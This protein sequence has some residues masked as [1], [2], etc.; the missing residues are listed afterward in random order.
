MTIRRSASA[1]IAR[2]IEEFVSGDTHRRELASARLA[3]IGSRATTALLGLATDAARPTIVRTSALETLQAIGDSRA[4]ALAHTLAAEP[5]DDALAVAAIDLLGQIARGADTRAT[6]AFDRLASIVVA[7]EASTTRRLA[8]LTA[9][10]GQPENLLKPLY[11]SLAKDPASK[12]VARAT[13]RQAG[14]VESL[15]T[16]VSRGLPGDPDIIGAVVR[17]DGDTTPLTTLKKAIDAIRL[18]ERAA[19]GD[20]RA[21]WAV[22]RGAV[23]QLLAARNSRLGLYDLRETLEQAKGPLPVGFLSAAAVVGDA[24]CLTPIAA[25]WM[26]TSPDDRWWREH[27]ADAF[28]SIVTREGL[29]R[30]NPVLTKI[31]AKWPGAGVL[32]A[33]ARQNR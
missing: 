1:D 28:R 23:H 7:S 18:R 29:T 26:D 24:A 10:E 3:V 6:R 8:S 30:R 25:A 11:E 17:E 19:T 32:V 21:R 33:M 15:D 12:V 13:R 5:G 4:A 22:V 9:L 16:L 2:L 31:L 27:L 20:D 14:A